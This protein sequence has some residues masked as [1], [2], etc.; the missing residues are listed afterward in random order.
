RA[1]TA[2]NPAPAKAKIGVLRTLAPFLGRQRG[3]VLAWLVAL[4][5]SSTATLSLPVAV[6]L[7]I[8]RGFSDAANVNLAFAVLF[9]VALALAL[10]TALRFFFVS[11]LGERVIADL[12]TRLYGH[13]M[14]LEDRKSTRLNSSHVK[15][16]YAVFCLKKKRIYLNRRSM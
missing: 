13:L 11:L 12:R 15:I 6:R 9:T 4:A 3:L 5:A 14:G 8:D 1:A 10:A 7:M 2:Q 16:S